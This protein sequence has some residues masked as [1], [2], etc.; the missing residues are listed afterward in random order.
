[1]AW[2]LKWMTLIWQTKKILPRN[3][4]APFQMALG[5]Q[6]NGYVYLRKN[7]QPDMEVQA[8]GL[9]VHTQKGPS[10]CVTYHHRMHCRLWT[11]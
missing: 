3:N 10:D 9:W 5:R 1:M 11:L 6:V 8:Q 7:D 4:E 2:L